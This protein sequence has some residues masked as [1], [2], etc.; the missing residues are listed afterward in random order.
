MTRLLG[1]VALR[2]VIPPITVQRAQQ[3]GSETARRSQ[4]GAG[5]NVRQA[6]ELDVR[7]FDRHQPQSLAHDGVTD[8]LGAIPLPSSST[9]R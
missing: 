8:F 2:H 5:G 9:G 4:S 3:R 6:G 7:I 1:N